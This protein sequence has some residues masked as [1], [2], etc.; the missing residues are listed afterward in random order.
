M[1]LASACVIDRSAHRLPRAAYVVAMTAIVTLLAYHGIRT[2]AARSTFA[3][4]RGERR[5]VDVARFVAEH[6][7]PDAVMLGLQHTGSLRLYAGRLTLKYDVLDPLW[8]DRAVEFLRTSGRHPYFV[9][10]G[11]EVDA[12][13]QR[14]GPANRA[15]TLDWQPIATLGSVVSVY[16]PLDRKSD[17][18]L[19]IASTR[20]R[21]WFACDLP[22]SW[23]P[24]LR[25]K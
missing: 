20:G 5:Y 13:R 19:A 25:M 15:G 16:D 21:A 22:Q 3:L 4:G 17:M 10:D 2:A 23:P 6:T 7:E 8:L 24:R 11:G 9:L 14:F 1:M 18:P 12:F